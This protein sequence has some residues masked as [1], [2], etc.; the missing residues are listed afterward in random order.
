MKALL[1]ML[2]DLCL[3]RIGPQ[4]LPYSPPLTR[5]LII[6][7]VG[8]GLL[9]VLVLGGGE[10]D[11]WQL[12]ISVLLMLLIPRLILRLRRREARY[13]QTQAALVGTGI[14]FTL[15]LTALAL[16]LASGPTPT[17]D[18]PP[19]PLQG[20]VALLWLGLVCWKLS[21]NGNI[22][23]HALDWP[24]G[25]GLLLAIATLVVELAVIQMLL[26]APAA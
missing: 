25:A 24:K 18:T 11:L 4:D 13:A 1:R 14:P 26:P 21:I 5:A 3:L 15:L 20:T 10:R 2:L 7:N 17:G 6:V 9:F 12:A 23:R 16:V 8:L 19:T 22:W